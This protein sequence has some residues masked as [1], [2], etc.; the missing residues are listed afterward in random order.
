MYGGNRG[1]V[2]WIHTAFNGLNTGNFYGEG[3]KTTDLMVASKP[4]RLKP[5]SL[6][7]FQ[8]KLGITGQ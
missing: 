7:Q 2:G 4:T 8:A 1:M 3:L 6:E 5:A